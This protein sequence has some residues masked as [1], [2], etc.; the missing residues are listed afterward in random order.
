MPMRANH[1]NMTEKQEKP[2]PAKTKR[3]PVQKSR[4]GMRPTWKR[5]LTVLAVFVTAA[6]VAHACSVPV[7]KYALDHWA[8]DAYQ[9][10]IFHQEPLSE[11][12][13]A[14]VDQLR[15]QAKE[16]AANV[17]VNVVDLNA[18][19]DEPAAEAWKRHADKAVD[20]PHCVVLMPTGVRGFGREIYSG[21]LESNTVATLLHSPVRQ[22]IG[23]F[24]VDGTSVVWVYLE[25]GDQQEDDANVEVLEKELAR[26]EEE[27]KLPE[28]DSA[29]TGEL[30]GD[31]ED[32]KLTMKLVRVSRT[33]EQ[34]TALVEML[35]SVEPDLREANLVS[36]PMVFPVFGRGRAL[37]ALVGKGI[38]SSTIE[39][40]CV[41]LTGPCQCTV[42]AENP[43]V[44][45]LLPVD[46][47]RLIEV[48]T[49]A[50]VDVPLTGLAS[51]ANDEPMDE[52]S[53]ES[54][55]ELA[56]AAGGTAPPAAESGEAASSGDS[57]PA[58][59]GAGTTGTSSGASRPESGS[60]G[61]M[62]TPL[63]IL[64]LLALIVAV[65]SFAALPKGS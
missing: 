16:T 38:N 2:M 13:A 8:P 52:G 56:V 57:T 41:F 29:D 23:E 43:G 27:L 22:K 20:D 17:Q 61:A 10:F 65:V 42:K 21:E 7:F 47:E 40:A 64:G 36:H 45:L 3:S 50:E 26:L 49:P 37:Y 63:L 15:T 39:D 25:S 54:G 12:D 62:W 31:P 46:W 28:I 35:L 33:D 9:V 44:D 18:E 1:S 11:A 58:A 51:F 6:T 24:L 48:P 55:T 19:M 30:A 53:D 34:E 60:V 4:H 5:V 59:T 14:R 32:L